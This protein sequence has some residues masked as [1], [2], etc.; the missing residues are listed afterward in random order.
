MI[1]EGILDSVDVVKSA[2]LDGV[3]MGAILL[4]A[5]VAIIKDK[6]YTR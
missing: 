2:F 1:E 3:S 5:E 4:T 6:T